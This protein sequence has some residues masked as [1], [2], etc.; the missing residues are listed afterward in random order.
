MNKRMTE[1]DKE[2]IRKSYLINLLP[3][4]AIAKEIHRNPHTIWKF[5]R[6]ERLTR[7]V[8]EANRIALNSHRKVMPSRKGTPGSSL[9]N[10]KGGRTHHKQGYILVLAP[11]HPAGR[12]NRQVLEHRL[13]MEKYLGRYLLPTEFVHHIN[14]VKDDNRI[15][16]LALMATNKAHRGLHPNIVCPHCGKHFIL[17]N[18]TPIQK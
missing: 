8:G 6:K 12:Y 4:S 5:L 2:F 9:Y 18:G 3:A 13:I 17:T 11:D 14:G 16:N 7:S 15:E 1:Q 10:W